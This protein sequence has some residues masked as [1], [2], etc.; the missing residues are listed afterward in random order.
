MALNKGIWDPKLR[1]TNTKGT[2]FKS[3]IC[4]GP[5]KPCGLLATGLRLGYTQVSHNLKAG[6]ASDFMG[7]YYRSY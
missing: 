4:N 1:G 7:D 5:R 3:L 2:N 6:D